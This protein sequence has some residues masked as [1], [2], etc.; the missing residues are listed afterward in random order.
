M[1]YI[2]FLIVLAASGSIITFIGARTINGRK[3]KMSA[4][5][6]KEAKHSLDDSLLQLRRSASRLPQTSSND[7]DFVKRVD[8]YQ[9]RNA[10][11]NTTRES[12]TG[13][14]Y[15]YKPP[16]KRRSSAETSG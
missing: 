16:P 12:I 3:Q 6:L 7:I 13:T 1:E 2:Y 15:E 4:R 9:V 14:K 5:S 10:W 8:V 11:F